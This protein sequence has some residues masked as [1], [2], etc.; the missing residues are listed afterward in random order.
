MKWGYRPSGAMAITE[1]RAQLRGQGV[2][3]SSCSRRRDPVDD[4]PYTGCGVAEIFTPGANTGDIA[5]LYAQ[6]GGRPSTSPTEDY[7]IA[8]SHMDLYEHQGK[9][10]SAPVT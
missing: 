8:R 10:S 7:S 3:T 1:G 9:G 5:W 2:A 6:L 4:I